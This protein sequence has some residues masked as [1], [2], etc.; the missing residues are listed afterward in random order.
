MNKWITKKNLVYRLQQL[1]ILILHLVLLKWMMYALNNSGKYTTTEVML[2][3]A[4]MA[5][6]GALL[7]RGC[8]WWAKRRY[9]KETGRDS[10]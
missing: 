7:I 8:A 9:L 5:I 10:L 1:L 4:G 6:Y 3:F 2:H